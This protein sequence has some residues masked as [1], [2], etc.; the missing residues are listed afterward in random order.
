MGSGTV[1]TL[2][3]GGHVVRFA[4]SERREDERLGAVAA[5]EGRMLRRLLAAIREGDTFFDV[6][7]NIGTVTLPVA[8]AGAVE[9]LAFEPEPTNA[10]RLGE[11]VELNGLVNVTVL[12]AA[13]WSA[14]GELGLRGGGPVG[15]G[16]AAVAEEEAAGAVRVAAT[17]IDEVTARGRSAPDLLKVDAEGA[18]LEVL[19]GAAET[20]GGGRVREVFVETHPLALAE[21]GT[22]EAGVGSLLRELGYAE[23]WSATR[24]GETHRHFRRMP[25]ASQG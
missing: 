6:G 22:S 24:A 8:L 2:R 5:D 19:R 14:T 23:T 3:I 7:A 25:A 4:V 1:R 15:S 11:N 9:C 12:E 18:E 16:T 10:A 21:R 13:A 20:L 17:T